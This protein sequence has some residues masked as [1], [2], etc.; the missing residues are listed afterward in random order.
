M[1]DITAW[2]LNTWLVISC[3]FTYLLY[4]ENGSPPKFI[5]FCPTSSWFKDSLLLAALSLTVLQL[6]RVI[7]PCCLKVAAL[8]CSTALAFSPSGI[9]SEL[10][11]IQQSV[12]CWFGQSGEVIDWLADAPYC[13][14]FPLRQVVLAQLY[15]YHPQSDNVASGKLV[16]KQHKIII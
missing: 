11:Q 7:I 2:K 1:L 13:L 8:S 15:K 16:W 4:Q 5:A 10:N 3:I 6:H 9:A 12:V 14:V